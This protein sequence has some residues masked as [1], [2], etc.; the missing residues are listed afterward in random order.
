[1]KK[2]LLLA[3]LFLS[4]QAM[5]QYPLLRLPAIYSDH[6]VLQQ[7]SEIKFWG[8][9][10]PHGNVKIIPSWSNDTIVTKTMGS[11]KWETLLKTP[12]AG[13]PYKIEI[14]G[15]NKSITIQD[16]MIGELW[17]CGGQS[18]MEWSASKITDGREAIPNSE[19]NQ[20]RFFMIDKGRSDFPQEDLAGKWFVCGPESLK[21][22]SA[23]GYFFG[24]NLQEALQMPIGLLNANWGGTAIETWIP[25]KQQDPSKGWNNG[26][27]TT[28]NTMIHPLI[29]TKLAG[30]IWYQGE[31][32]CHNAN[33]YSQ[34]QVTLM[35]RWREK[36]QDDLPF[37][38]VQIA[39]YGRYTVPLSA[40]VVREQQDKVMSLTHKTGMVVINDQVDEINNIHPNYKKEV[41]NRLS[42]WALAETY[43]KS[44]AK[45]KHATLRNTRIDKNKIY[46]FFDNIEPGLQIKGKDVVGL[47]I[48]GTDGVFYAAVGKV[49]KKTN[50][51]LVESKK[52]MK[53]VYVRYCFSNDA[54]GNLFDAT[55]LPVAPFRTDSLSINLTH[56]KGK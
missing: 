16:I 33:Q 55:G 52:V 15:F 50:S 36:F 46:V 56:P 3:S 45:Y 18:N 20:I 40:A 4:L 5:A 8:W 42:N 37:Y 29:G 38:Y 26:I 22:F 32:N 41:G 23:L 53:P 39:P 48:A 1:M 11:A 49:D 43:G 31:A 12:N 14:I 13:G 24:K 28:Y 9:S 10:A 6:A 27:G 25:Q 17:L 54:I 19:N 44:T 51:L 30:V 35:E 2:L 21:N 7:N 47:E 34:L